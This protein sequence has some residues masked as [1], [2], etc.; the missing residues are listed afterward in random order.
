M[1]NANVL[2][3]TK[4]NFDQEVLKSPVPVVLDFW[5]EWC[6]P[7]KSVGVFLEQF[8][9][10]YAGKLKIAKVNIDQEQDLAAQFRVNA[11]PTLLFFKNGAPSSQMVGMK[12][13]KEFM[14][15]IDRLLT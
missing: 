15:E 9:L 1:A 10:E 11:I 3:V 8:A 2:N 13:R 4:A 14:A 6:G 5:A 7:C 12:T